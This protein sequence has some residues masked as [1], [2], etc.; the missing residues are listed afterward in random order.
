MTGHLVTLG[1]TMAV[2]SAAQVGPLSSNRDMRL[3]LAG[4][5]SNV[6]IGARRLGT[7]VTWISRLGEDGFGELIQRELRAE[8][9][10]VAVRVDPTRPTGLMVK[11]RPNALRT[12]VR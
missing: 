8:G 6:A 3:S 1:E 2:F 9:V 11:E 7:R 12:H 5:E 4:A 10:G